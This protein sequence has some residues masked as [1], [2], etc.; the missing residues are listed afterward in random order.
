MRG[1]PVDVP[2][3]ATVRTSALANYV[4][5]SDRNT[6]LYTVTSA[7]NGGA[8]EAQT[9]SAANGGTDASASG[10]GMF[11]MNGSVRPKDLEDGLSNTFSVGEQDSF[12]VQHAGAASRSWRWSSRPGR[13]AQTRHLRLFAVRTRARPSSRWRTDRSTQS[14]RPS[15]RWSIRHLPLLT[16]KRSSI[17]GPTDVD[18]RRLSTSK[19]T[20]KA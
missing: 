16:V 14:R 20:R 7:V 15:T 17:W 6:G 1:E 10:N 19:K 13:T 18:E 3:N 8:V 2:A 12:M 4:C 11:R 5:P 9:T